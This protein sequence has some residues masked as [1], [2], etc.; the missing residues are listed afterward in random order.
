MGAHDAERGGSLRSRDTSRS[1]RPTIRCSLPVTTLSGRLATTSR[2]ASASRTRSMTPA[3]SV[4]RGGYG[5][6]YNRTILGAVDDTI[7]IG[8]YTDS[9]VVNFPNSTADPGPSAGRLPTDPLLVNGPIVN[10]ALLNQMF[11]PGARIKNAGVVDLRRAEPPTA[12]SR[13]RRRSGL[14]A[15]CRGIWRS[16][17]TTCIPPTATCFWREI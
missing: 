3:R 14:R 1:T 6:F 5:L 7:E 10:R 17:P 16:T 11:P 12:V 15:S 2:R 9:N 13:I 8:K 4:I